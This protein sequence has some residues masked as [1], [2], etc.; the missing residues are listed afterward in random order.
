MARPPNDESRDKPRDLE[1]RLLQE[2]ADARQDYESVKR[3]AESLMRTAADTGY[4]SP[5]GTAAIKHATLLERAALRRYT[6][7]SVRF[8]KFILNSAE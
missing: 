4:P 5:D 3:I 8:S 6:E 1:A 7:A 2:V